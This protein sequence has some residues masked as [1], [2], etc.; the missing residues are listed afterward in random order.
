MTERIDE[1]TTRRV[2]RPILRFGTVAFFLAPTLILL[3][4]F[5]YYPF[6]TAFFWSLFEWDRATDPVFLG[7]GNFKKLLF[8]D[9][10]FWWSMFVVGILLVANLTKMLTMPLLAAKLVYNL[11]N[12]QLRFVLQA[13]FVVPLVIPAVVNVLLWRYMYSYNGLVNELLRLVG[14]EQYVQAWLGDETTVIPAIIMMGFPWVGVSAAF[15]LYLA[16]MLNIASDLIDAAKV[17]GATAW[18]RFWHVELPLLRGQIR[19][20]VILITLETV[21]GFYSIYLLS[22][23]GPGEI[24][25]VP[26][27]HMFKQAFRYSYY[28]YASSIGVVLFAIMMTL[29]Y[30]NS[31]YIRSGIEYEA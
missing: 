19:L 21:Q 25:M 13:A 20:V 2:P 28:G 9:H 24:S 11:R 14:L 27:L 3:L 16:G 29:T 22:G 10:T 30:L 5:A 15:L 17:D 26:G 12:N 6:L 1:S 7:V 18:R 4:I 8:E 23:G 31:R